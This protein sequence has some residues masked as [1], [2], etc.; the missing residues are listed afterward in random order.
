VVLRAGADCERAVGEFADPSAA[1]R[2][3][4]ANGFEIERRYRPNLLLLR[5]K[6][7]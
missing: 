4:A 1:P 6:R 5:R 3:I 7:R 2:L